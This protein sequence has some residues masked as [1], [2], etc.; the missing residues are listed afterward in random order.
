MDDYLTGLVSKGLPNL[1]NE[2]LSM[3][4]AGVKKS[5]EKARLDHAELSQR[6]PILTPMRYV[7]AGIYY[8]ALRKE[9]EKEYKKRLGTNV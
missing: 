1:S 7:R 2:E 4:L 6:E 9:I 8:E 5:E 3:L